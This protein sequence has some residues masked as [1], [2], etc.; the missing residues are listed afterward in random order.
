MKNKYIALMM[1]SA[2]ALMP[3]NASAEI[4]SLMVKDISVTE[5]SEDTDT[6][7]TETTTIT[8]PEQGEKHSTVLN[9]LGKSLVYRF[10]PKLFGR[11]SSMFLGPDLPASEV[12]VSP[13]LR[14]SPKIC[15][16]LQ[17]S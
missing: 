17:M 16:L 1:A 14:R 5:L 4:T 7:Q 2:M 8:A 6:S 15:I 3:V 10:S 13:S 9:A 12:L 11:S